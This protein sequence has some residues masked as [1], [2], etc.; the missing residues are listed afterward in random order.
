MNIKNKMVWVLTVMLG[1]SLFA[2]DR[3]DDVKA[4]YNKILSEKE[5]RPNK[6]ASSLFLSYKFQPIFDA[7]K[8]TG[9]RQQ[10]KRLLTSSYSDNESFLIESLA[11][12]SFILAIA[13]MQNKYG[14]GQPFAYKNATSEGTYDIS[15][16]IGDYISPDNKKI[17]MTSYS[18]FNGLL[19]ALVELNNDPSQRENPHFKSIYEMFVKGLSGAIKR[20]EAYTLQ[21]L[22]PL[23]SKIEDLLYKGNKQVIDAVNTDII[24]RL[25]SII[26]NQ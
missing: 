3:Q 13:F 2:M 8:T 11:D 19:D 26:N 6:P 18:F 20:P 24:P 15:P 21:K 4:L 16:V 23:V 1:Y 12:S 5:G 17:V 22:K 7:A 9:L 14:G 10:Y 25:E